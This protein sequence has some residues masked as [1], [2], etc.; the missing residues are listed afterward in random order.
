V[1]GGKGRGGGGTIALVLLL[2]M[3]NAACKCPA[4]AF[5]H[6]VGGMQPISACQAQASST[7]PP[8]AP[9]E[10]P[11]FVLDKQQLLTL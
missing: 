11:R 6:V 7:A 4:T 8:V 2:C 1:G 10:L 5:S 9:F 3:Q